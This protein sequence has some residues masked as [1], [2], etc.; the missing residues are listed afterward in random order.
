MTDEMKELIDK[1]AETLKAAG[2]R[3]VYLFGSAASGELTAD[4][5]IDIAVSGVPPKNFFHAMSQTSAIFRRSL[6]L[7]DLDEK[8]PFTEYLRSKGKLNRVA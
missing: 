6:D 3:E 1:A 8:T 4:S 7:V 5:D 2:A